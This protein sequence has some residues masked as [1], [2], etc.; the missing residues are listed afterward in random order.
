MADR[1]SIT[2]SPQ[3]NRAK[4]TAETAATV[5][6]AAPIALAFLAEIGIVVADAVMAGKLGTTA[7]AAEGLGAH[8]LFTPQLLAMGV[9]SSI[10]ALDRKSVV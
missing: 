2:G 3:E 4:W 9:L 1:I 7:L 8:L 10:A 6:L 5:K